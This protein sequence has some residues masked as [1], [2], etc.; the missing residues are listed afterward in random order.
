M[1]PMRSSNWSNYGRW[2]PSGRPSRSTTVRL[3]IER[4]CRITRD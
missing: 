2:T 1:P 4:A 3:M